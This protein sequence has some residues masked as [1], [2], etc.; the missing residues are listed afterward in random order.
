MGTNAKVWS[1]IVWGAVLGMAGVVLAQEAKQ[2]VSSKENKELRADR[3]D[4]L[5]DRKEISKRAE[6]A[7]VQER[8]L[9]EQVAQ[10]DR[11][12]DLEKAAQLRDQLKVMHDEHVKEMQA[13]RKK[14]HESWKGL[15][16]EVKEADKQ[17]EL[18]PEAKEKLEAIRKRRE[19]MKEQVEKR[20]GMMEKE[21]ATKSVTNSEK[22][23]K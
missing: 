3:K 8:D 10:A 22:V 21:E 13:E 15:K 18:S 7:R 16:G 2:E 1:V 4:I 11:A 9:R 20:R 23:S 5:E 14:L 6:E 19:S 12:G 17:G